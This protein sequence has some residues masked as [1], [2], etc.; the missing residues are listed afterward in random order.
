ML[1]V[2]SQTG[3]CHD[4]NRS[5][6]N[7]SRI[8]MGWYLNRE[9]N[10]E[11]FYDFLMQVD[12]GLHPSWPNVP[13]STQ[14]VHFIIYKGHCISEWIYEVI[15]SSKIWTKNCKDFCPLALHSAV[16]G[17][18]P[19]NICSIRIELHNH[20]RLFHLQFAFEQKLQRDLSF[21]TMALNSI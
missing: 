7:I 3:T 18:N 9:R 14:T 15:V 19:F 12:R 6:I 8:K 20:S 17:R 5:Q 10:H 13:R 2:A 16:Q 1:N 4:L 11:S 21:F